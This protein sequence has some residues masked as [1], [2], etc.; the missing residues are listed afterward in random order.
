[1]THMTI[2]PLWDLDDGVQ[3]GFQCACG[4]CQPTASVF[5]DDPRYER[6]DPALANGPCCCGRF[7]VVGHDAPA[8]AEAMSIQFQRAGM[9]PHGH[10]FRSQA[11]ALPWGSDVP[12]IVADLVPAGSDA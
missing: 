8:Q 7:F 6:H 1:M 12:A 4:A 11:V 5:R 10:A 2:Q 3:V 9:A